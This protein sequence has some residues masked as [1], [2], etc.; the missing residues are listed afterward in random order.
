MGIGLPSGIIKMIA[1]TSAGGYC[2]SCN[3]VIKECHSLIKS[4]EKCNEFGW[5]PKCMKCGDITCWECGCKCDGY[6]YGNTTDS[7]LDTDSRL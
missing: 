7:M 1:E 3:I 2:S 5:L 6:C 4:N